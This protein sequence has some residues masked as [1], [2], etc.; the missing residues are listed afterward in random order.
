LT[1]NYKQTNE[2]QNQHYSA[3][4]QVSKLILRVASYTTINH[5][6]IEQQATRVEECIRYVGRSWAKQRNAKKV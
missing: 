2:K 3:K 6:A 5:S 4:L 1:R